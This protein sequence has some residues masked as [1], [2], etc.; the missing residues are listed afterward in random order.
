LIS[1]LEKHLAS[2]KR[3]EVKESWPADPVAA[4]S[5]QNRAG[6]PSELCSNHACHRQHRYQPVESG[7]FLDGRDESCDRRRRLFTVVSHLRE[8]KGYTYG[9]Y[10]DFS[11]LHYPGPWRAAVICAPK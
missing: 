9:V 7:L 5:P 6:Q 8:E 11:A 10:S 2:W 3:T 4:K 1:K